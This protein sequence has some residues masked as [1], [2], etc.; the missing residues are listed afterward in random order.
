[1][2]NF[3]MVLVLFAVNFDVCSIAF[4][5]RL[6]NGVR[7]QFHLIHNKANSGAQLCNDVNLPKYIGVLK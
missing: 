2:K 7:F 4:V 1:M 6:L 5:T 3:L